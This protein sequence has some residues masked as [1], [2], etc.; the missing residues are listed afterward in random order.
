MEMNP[1]I[2]CSI[3]RTALEVVPPRVVGNFAKL[4]CRACEREAFIKEMSK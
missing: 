2:R 1:P 4:V 3:H